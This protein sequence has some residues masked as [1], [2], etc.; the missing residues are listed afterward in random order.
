[1]LAAMLIDADRVWFFKTMGPPDRLAAHKSEFDQ[2]ISSI[3]INGPK[4]V[5]PQREYK[6]ML[7]WIAPRGW[8]N[9]GER[10]LREL[11]Y[12][13]GN[14]SDP[15]EIMVTKLRGTTFGDLLTN[16]N[17]WRAQVGLPEVAK[18]ADQ[19]SQRIELAKNPAASFDFVGPG[20]EQTPNRRM[21]LIMSVVNNDVW[22]FKMLGPQQTV[23]AEKQNFDDFLKSV[24]FAGEK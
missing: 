3:K 6:E 9:G 15:A 8:K 1:M 14:P 20:N 24:Q 17:R 10:T 18:V 2:F 7:S 19:P 12:Y 5:G 11:T 4:E 13:A 23:A 16:I 21:L 22:F